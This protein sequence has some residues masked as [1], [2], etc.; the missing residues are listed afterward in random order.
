MKIIRFNTKQAAIDFSEKE[1]DFRNMQKGSDYMWGWQEDEI[2][3]Y[4]EIGEKYMPT[5]TNDY[6]LETKEVENDVL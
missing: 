3:W 5:H 2:G 1:A 6:I 4:L